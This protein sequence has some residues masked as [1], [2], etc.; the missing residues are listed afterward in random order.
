MKSLDPNAPITEWALLLQGPP[1]TGKTTL[2]CQFPKPWVA[3]SLNN[4]SGPTRW[5]QANRPAQIPHIR[6][7]TIMSDD[8]GDEV[9]LGARWPRLLNKINEARKSPEVS[10]IVLDDL[11]MIC[12]FLCD[13]IVEQKPSGRKEGMTISDWIPFRKLLTQLITDQRR[14]SKRLV[15]TC[16]EEYDKDERLGTIYT[17]I[18]IPSKLSS[19]F[20]GFFTDVWRTEVT[21]MGG[22]LVYS[23]RSQPTPA[24]PALGN[25]LGLPASWVFSW[26]GMAKYLGDRP[27]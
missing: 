4:L 1:K 12:E 19:N 15:V 11:G 23:V 9:P 13:Y 22:Q 21:E 7:D 14:M 20:G 10:T 6:Q 24:V 16:H 18:N 26:E 17:K 8:N 2:A 3:N 27:L 25:S 5:L